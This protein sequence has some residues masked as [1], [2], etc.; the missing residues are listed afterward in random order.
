MKKYSAVILA[1]GGVL[2]ALIMVVGINMASQGAR[3]AADNPVT[4]PIAT[5]HETVAPGVAKEMNGKTSKVH[6]AGGIKMH[7][8]QKGLTGLAGNGA[9][10]GCLKQY[11]EPGQCLPLVSPA[12]ASMPDMNHP[13]TCADVIQLFPAGVTVNGKDTLH[14][15]YN[16]DGIAC[17]KGDG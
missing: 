9:G 11:G 15:D 14:L 7:K 6:M 1:V 3:Q 2:A 17:N 13:W 10:N 12:Q 16:G 4:T 5:P 8:P